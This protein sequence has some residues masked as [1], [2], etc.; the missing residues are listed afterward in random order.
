M[1][2]DEAQKR[3]HALHAN[4]RS[5]QETSTDRVSALVNRHEVLREEV[6]ETIRKLDLLI[7]EH[8]P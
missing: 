8:G 4:E 2:I 3:S 1:R 7:E 5:A 6:A